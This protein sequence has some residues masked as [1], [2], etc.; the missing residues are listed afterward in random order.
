MSDAGERATSG[1]GQA[2][3]AQN[4]EATAHDA[5][6][7]PDATAPPDAPAPP[8]TP[9]KKRRRWP[10]GIELFVAIMLG[11]TAIA[12][13]YAAWRNEQRNHDAT[14]Q[15][16]EGIRDYDDG[17]QFYAEGQ[18]VLSRDE[19]LFLEYAKAKQLNQSKL[20]TYIFDNLMSPTLQAGVR[21]WEGPNTRTSHPARNPFTPHDPEYKIQQL[22]DAN[23]SY[24][25]SKNKFREARAEQE[26]A[27]HYTLIEVI[28][29]T[30]LFLYGVAGVTGNPRSKRAIVLIGTAIFLI[31]LVFLISG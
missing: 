13:A 12:S 26:K 1:E 22:T 7:T 24:D 5:P 9:E 16:S 31:A 14:A 8:E 29:A 30:S 25:T 21:W 11:L 15:F 28:L 17:G 4:D 10:G 6:A 23:Q 18:S 19:S 27:D 3:G 2:P 20:A